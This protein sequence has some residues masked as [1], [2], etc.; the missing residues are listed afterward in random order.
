MSADLSVNEFITIPMPKENAWIQ[1][2]QIDLDTKKVIMSLS[3]NY[4][5]ARD[6]FDDLRC[7]EA[8]TE[9]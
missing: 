8:L 2:L 4:T 6:T 7:Y 9:D 3:N 1:E 5:S